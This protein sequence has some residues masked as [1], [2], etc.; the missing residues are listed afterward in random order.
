LY[1]EQIAAAMFTLKKIKGLLEWF[2]RLFMLEIFTFQCF[3][4]VTPFVVQ[5]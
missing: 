4:S 3:K 1:P 2:A 5:E